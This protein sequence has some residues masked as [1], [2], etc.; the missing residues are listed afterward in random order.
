M[1]HANPTFDPNQVLLVTDERETVT[2]VSD[3]LMTNGA[4][5]GS[6]VCHSLSQLVLRL[7]STKTAA[8][9]VDI[10]HQPERTLA[11]LEAVIARFPDSRFVVLSRERGDSLMIEAMQVGARHF[12]V[13]HSIREELADI[14]HRL[15][16]GGPLKRKTDGPMVTVL[17]A[18]GGCGA[19]SIAVNLAKELHLLSGEQTLL[20]D[21]DCYYGGIATYLGLEGQYGLGDVLAHRAAID[22]D[23]IHTTSTPSG[24]GMRTLLSPASTNFR[25]SGPLASE[26]IAEAVEALSA[27]GTTTVI[28][29]PRLGSVV[30]SIVARSSRVTL[31]VFQLCVKDI[32]T[33]KAMRA[34]LLES[35]IEPE[36]IL[37][38]A[39]R[40]RKRHSIV[41]LDDA[42]AVLGNR[43]ERLQNDYKAASAAQNFGQ[44]LADAAP[45]S[46]LRRDIVRLAEIIRK[47]YLLGHEIPALR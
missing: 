30:E 21:L 44:P 42:A 23:L 34:G 32:R 37:S 45:R 19:T 22:S 6:R 28:D 40:F 39:N 20:V 33:A 3:A 24:K 14:L 25:T 4:F 27:A 47:N 18:S 8:V 7:E 16:P 2:A 46:V 1:V 35:G 13:K 11:D 9:L 38:V 41:N 36:R 31:L 10:D 17:S 26:R 12:L 43:V 5:A 15:V 29:A